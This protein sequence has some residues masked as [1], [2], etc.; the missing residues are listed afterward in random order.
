MQPKPILK[1]IESELGLVLHNVHSINN[2]GCGIFAEHLYYT[3]SKAGLEPIITVIGKGEEQIKEVLRNNGKGSEIEF[4]H[5][6]LYVDGYYI[7]SGGLMIDLP[8]RWINATLVRGMSIDLLK[9]WNKDE[10]NWNPC[11]DRSQIKYIE[12]GFKKIEKKVLKDL[13][14]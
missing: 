5:I 1:A 8:L 6:V 9:E 2:G 11:F 14:D 12:G 10:N 7:D 4:Y 13:E 3:L